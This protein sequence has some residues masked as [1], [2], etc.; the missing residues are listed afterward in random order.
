MQQ[1]VFPTRINVGAKSSTAGPKLS[2]LR[3]STMREHS[4][5]LGS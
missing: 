2:A 4:Q 5:L 1:T 3:E